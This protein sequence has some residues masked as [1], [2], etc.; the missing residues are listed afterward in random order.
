[1]VGGAKREVDEAK[2]EK[3]KRPA[4]RTTKKVRTATAFCYASDTGREEMSE[5][6]RAIDLDA[7]SWNPGGEPLR[8]ELRLSDVH[9]SRTRA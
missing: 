8:A 3:V 7:P 2:H 4:V 6:W 1:M 5:A 9:T